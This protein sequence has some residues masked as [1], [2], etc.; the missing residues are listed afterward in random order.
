MAKNFGQST[1]KYLQEPIFVGIFVEKNC[2]FTQIFFQDWN[3]HKS[4]WIR[5]SALAKSQAIWKTCYLQLLSIYLNLTATLWQLPDDYLT[6]AWSS[7]IILHENMTA[8][9][10]EAVRRQKDKN[11]IFMRLASATDKETDESLDIFIVW[12]IN[13]GLV[14]VAGSY[15]WKK[16]F[17]PIM[18]SFWG[19]FFMF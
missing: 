17:G 14:W 16:K 11:C 1:G 7:N 4:D 9:K 19:P 13:Y 18:S 6:T 12:K 3:W 8:Q 15:L 5:V 2:S 10:L